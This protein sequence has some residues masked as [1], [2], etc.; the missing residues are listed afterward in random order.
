MLSIE[1]LRSKHPYALWLL[2]GLMDLSEIGFFCCFNFKLA[3]RQ[4]T[5]IILVVEQE[6]LPRRL[7]RWGILLC[8]PLRP[9]RV[10]SDRCWSAERVTGSFCG[11]TLALGSLDR[12]HCAGSAL[13]TRRSG[14]TSRTSTP[15]RR[16]TLD[17]WHPGS[18]AA[19]HA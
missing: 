19:L 4:L 5:R 13:C 10:I 6:N 9:W 16:A 17:G 18:S 15:P 11:S 8:K 7:H 2:P 14:A 1:E 3:L 12:A